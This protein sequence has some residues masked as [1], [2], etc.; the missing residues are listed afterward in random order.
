MG[1]LLLA[2]F[3]AE[4]VVCVFRHGLL[5]FFSCSKNTVIATAANISVQSVIYRLKPM[6]I[7]KIIKA[8]MVNS[9]KYAPIVPIRSAFSITFGF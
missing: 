2:G 5:V 1:L 4:K 9:H 6:H 3:E 8:Q 7:L